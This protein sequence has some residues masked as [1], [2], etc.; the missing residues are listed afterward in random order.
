[1]LRDLGLAAFPI[2]NGI[3][4]SPSK[5]T[6]NARIILVK[7]F[8]NPLIG[9]VEIL[10]ADIIQKISPDSFILKIIFFYNNLL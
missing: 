5:D 7:I 3:G 10:L 9:A 4:L 1:M 8:L 2:T 6:V